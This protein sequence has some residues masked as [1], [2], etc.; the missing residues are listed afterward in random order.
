MNLFDQTQKY[1]QSGAFEQALQGYQA[2]LAADQDNPQLCYL[3]ALLFFEQEKMGEAAHWFNRVITLA[4]EAAPAH[5]NL[6]VIFFEQGDYY[7]AAQAYEEAAKLCPED[8]DIFFNLA[9]TRKKLGQF[10]KAFSC[11]Q[12]ALA[13]TPEAEDVLY[14]I[15]VLCKDMHHHADGIWFFEKV[16]QNNPDHAPALNNLGYLY[17]MERQVDKAITVYHKLIALDHN[18]AMAAHMLAALTG[19]TTAT[20]PDSYIRA[21]FDSFSEHYDESLVEKLGYSTPGQLREMLTAQHRQH[22]AVTLDM[23][24]GTGLSG[25]A[26]QDV[27]EQLV[28][29]DLSPNMLEVAGKKRLYDSLHETDIGSFLRDNTMTF[30]LFI[31]ADVFVYIGDLQEIFS[32]VKK[33]AA[34]GGIFLFSTELAAHDFALQPMGRYG[35]AEAYIRGLAQQCG[36]VVDKVQAANIRKEKEEWISGNLYMLRA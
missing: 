1:H 20:A 4:P 29:L 23:G 22:F 36:F 17:H 19:Q 11:Y 21:V 24:C 31:A 3:L 28:G 30:D 14:N 25:E 18:S 34:Q 32:L 9:L 35:H 8:G 12:K 33:R 27:T 16:V 15:G 26:F 7:G 5:Y 2:L 10:D 13:I 6:G